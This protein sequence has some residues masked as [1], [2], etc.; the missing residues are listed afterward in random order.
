MLTTGRMPF[1]S[2]GETPHRA[3][4]AYDA[5]ATIAALVDYVGQLVPGGP[6]VPVGTAQDGDVAA[7]GE[8]FRAQ[9]AACHQWGGQAA[10]SCDAKLRGSTCRRRLKSS[11]RSAW[12]RAR[13]PCSAP[14]RS[15]TARSSPTWLAMSSTSSTRTIAAACPCGIS[16]PVP[17][18]GMALLAIGVLVFGLRYV[19]TADEARTVSR[20]DG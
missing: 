16:G 20:A 15:A 14:P 13:C 11:K 18:G 1:K 12:G 3:V 8:I 9:C 6:D 10:L 17:E 19:G 5:A 7:V 4:P 2:P